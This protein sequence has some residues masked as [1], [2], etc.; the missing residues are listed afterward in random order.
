[1]KKMMMGLIIICAMFLLVPTLSSAIP[2]F[3]FDIEQGMEFA[4]INWTPYNVSTIGDSC[5]T[6]C[7]GGG[8]VDIF[9]DE[10][11]DT[12]TG[13]LTIDI[14]IGNATFWLESEVNNYACTYLME[15]PS[16][17][18]SIC[19]DGVGENRLVFSAIYSTSITE[20][21][22]FNRDNG[23]IEFY[24]QTIIKNDLIVERNITGNIHYAEAWYH[25][26]TGEVLSFATQYYYYNVSL[27]HFDM[28]NGFE[29]G[30]DKLI[31][32]KEGLYDAS[33]HM[34]GSGQNNHRYVTIIG[35]NG[36]NSTATLKTEDHK[37][38]TAGGDLTGMD[39][40]GLLRLSVNDEISLMVKDEGGT[41]A[42][43][44]VGASITL[45]RIGD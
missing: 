31:C 22:S 37:K 36:Q 35:L 43:V 32:K 12:M 41:G 30:T 42:G 25:N 19:N 9:V 11:G 8:V 20:A 40:Q 28:L 17:G 27:D 44:Y 14:P 24:N 4:F 7:G 29:A 16:L 10:A 18:F 26:H 3:N 34:I 13:D 23:D 1:M 39:G 6:G 5:C 45:I 38:M 15:G 21:F 2:P 33:Y